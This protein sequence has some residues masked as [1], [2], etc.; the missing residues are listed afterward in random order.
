MGLE[1]AAILKPVELENGADCQ[2]SECVLI[3]SFSP[4]FF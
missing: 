1:E 3:A 4:I 2:S